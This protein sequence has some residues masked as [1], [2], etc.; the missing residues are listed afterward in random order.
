M[1][2]PLV[3]VITPTYNQ[4]AYLSQ[5]IESVLAQT[6]PRWQLIVVDDGSTDGTGDLLSQ[7]DDPRIQYVRLPHRGLPALAESYNAALAVAQGE[8]VAILEGDD[9]WPADKLE[10]GLRPFLDDQVFLVW[11]KGRLIDEIGRVVGVRTSVRGSSNCQIFSSR[12]IFAWL[13]RRNVL[14]PTNT[15]MVRRDALDRAGGFSQGGSSLYVD[16]PTWLRVMATSLGRVCYLNHVL[17]LYRVHGS[18]TTQRYGR[19]MAADHLG[20]V[21]SLEEELGVDALQTVGWDSEMRTR[22]IV[23]ARVGAGMVELKYQEYDAAKACFA[24][25]WSQASSA[26]ERA[27]AALGL[28]SSSVRFD[29]F[30]ATLRIRESVFST[31]EKWA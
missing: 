25:A 11:G 2:G 21:L 16:L 18:Q 23:A 5:C 31:L 14:T 24:E 12:Q 9:L 29:L 8:I 13:T 4:A 20:A 19:G 3:S 15:V 27:K 17:G 1:T 28:L 10:A 6:Y 22:A 7:Y 30:G 26:R